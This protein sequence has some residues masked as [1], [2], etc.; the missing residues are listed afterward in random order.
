MNLRSKL[1]RLA[2]H[3]PELRADLLPLVASGKKAGV[4]EDIDAYL[5]S[6]KS[7]DELAA[8]QTAKGVAESTSVTDA[9]S[10]FFA[11]EKRII[12]LL[13]DLRMALRMGDMNPSIIPVGLLDHAMRS[14][15]LADPSKV[16]EI[17]QKDRA[18]TYR[19]IGVTPPML[20]LPRITK[21]KAKSQ[22]S[23][24]NMAAAYLLRDLGLA[25]KKILGAILTL[26]KLGPNGSKAAALGAQKE[27]FA[28]LYKAAR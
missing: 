10:A 21:E 28:K 25:L 26:E 12:E 1:I 9:V 24:V 16:I 23:K 20:Y 8:E 5:D 15:L 19:L 17:L 7:P 27:L 6:L 11:A 18:R 3:H 4:D 13:I 14:S 22:W 2:A